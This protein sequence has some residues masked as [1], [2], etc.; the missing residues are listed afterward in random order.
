M[1]LQHVG[2]LLLLLY[3]K[4]PQNKNKMHYC[5]SNTSTNVRHWYERPLRILQTVNSTTRRRAPP[6]RAAQVTT[7]THKRMGG[8]I[9]KANVWKIHKSLVCCTMIGE[10]SFVCPLWHFTPSTIPPGVCQSSIFKTLQTHKTRTNCL[11]S[12]HIHSQCN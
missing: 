4:G 6:R 8:S 5:G 1:F 2:P 12:F 9:L 7:L 10:G 11:W 3:I